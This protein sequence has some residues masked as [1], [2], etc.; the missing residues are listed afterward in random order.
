MKRIT[1]RHTRVFVATFI[2]SFVML[3]AMPEVIISSHLCV[4][5][6]PET[7]IAV[8]PSTSV[9]NP[10]EYFSVNITI[11]DVA[12]L[13]SYQVRVGSDRDILK[14]IRATEGPFLKEGTTSPSG[15]YFLYRIRTE[16]Q[17]TYMEVACV[18]LGSY[19]GVSGGGTL[20]TVD[21]MVRD[22]GISNLSLSETILLDSNLAQIPHS[23]SNGIFHTRVPRAEFTFTEAYPTTEENVT[24]DASDSYDPD[25]TIVSYEWDFGDGTIGTG[26]VTT[27][28]YD[29]EGSYTITLQVTDD[30]GLSDDATATIHPRAPL[31]VYI[32]VP[33]YHQISGYHCGPAALEMVFDFYGPDIP[34]S[35]IADAARTAPD[36]T[37]TC[38]MVRAAH[39]SNLSTFPI[40][41]S[42]EHV[43]G[44]TARKL[45]YAAFEYWGV[46]I[47]QLKSLLTAGYPI[48]VLT[49]WHYRVAV[50]YSSTRIMFQDSYY[51]ENITLTYEA[52][53]STW[54]YSGHWA[55]FVSPWEIEVSV[56]H[57]VSVGS[58]FN[59][60]A[61]ITYPSP[62]PPDGDQYPASLANAT[63]TLPAGLSLDLGETV[64][65]PMDAGD[66]TVGTS[67]NVTWSVRA[68]SVGEYTV[69]VEAEGL[70]EGFVPPIPSYPEFYSYK[71]RIGGKKQCV[72]EVL[73]QE[74]SP[75]ENLEEIVET[76]NSWGLP[77]GIENSF[78]SKLEVALHLLKKGNV[79]GAIH[80]IMA[81]IKQV[82]A[83]RGKK[84]T[85]GQAD[86]LVLEAQRTIDL[87]QD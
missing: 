58:V 27:H 52:L 77:R 12:D 48:I 63:V 83:L 79:K 74:P 11:S 86:Y 67:A 4:L 10:G 41:G 1:L 34:Q 72:V 18:T 84:L 71:D 50:G 61:T 7:A 80:V 85:D 14:V 6:S 17:G 87:I 32:P 75:E 36:G 55:L 38:D 9:A 35:E 21:F 70:V 81:F 13:Y 40:G 31:L 54:D 42:P 37:Y 19:P 64:T 69:S 51:G 56:P 43:T 60:T 30:D 82:E 39:F 45:G 73:A 15:T 24:F 22:G 25:G 57:N 20:F 53:D 2:L 44:Y 33:Y 49:T 68:D 62:L 3:A 66:L 16:V 26:M 8:E 59:V 65:K 29:V 78:T 47:D 46:T 76:V 5:A 23:I 28:S